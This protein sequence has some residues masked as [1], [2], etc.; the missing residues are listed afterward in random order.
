MAASYNNLGVVHYKLGDF[1]KAKD[2]YELALS[3]YQKKLGPENVE[4]AASYNNLGVVNNKLGDFEKAKEYHQLALS[5]RQKKLGPENVQV[6]ASY[7]HLGVVHAEQSLLPYRD[8]CLLSQ[9]HVIFMRL[10]GSQKINYSFLRRQCS[11]FGEKI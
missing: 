1:E 8:Y 10:G 9:V 7:N 11:G 2:Y 3:I 6:A 4:V 5:I